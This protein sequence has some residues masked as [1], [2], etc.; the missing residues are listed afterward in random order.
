[1]RK[2]VIECNVP[3]EACIAELLDAER[4]LEDV[5]KQIE[6]LEKLKAEVKAAA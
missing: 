2:A 3:A 6:T 1:M 5:S 4:R